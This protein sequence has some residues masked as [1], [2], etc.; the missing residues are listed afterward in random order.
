[1]REVY[2][3]IWIDTVFNTTI[4]ELVEKGFDCFAISDL[5]YPNEAAR[6]HKEG[7]AVVE[8]IRD[9]SGVTVGHDHSSENAMKNYPDFDFILENNGSFEEYY[10]KL[11]RLLEEI[12][13]YGGDK[14]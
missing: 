4:P 14:R 1:M 6:I 2:P 13:Y 9:G 10:K 3:D 11:D 7:G 8:V 5:R 12:E